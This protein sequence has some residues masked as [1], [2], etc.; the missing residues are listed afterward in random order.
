MGGKIIA[1]CYPSGEHDML[2]IVEVPDDTTA[3]G[4]ALVV[5]AGGAVR[6][7]SPPGCWP[8]GNGSSACERRSSLN[9]AQPAG[10]AI[11]VMR[12]QNL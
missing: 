6:C 10:H 12:G 9:T 1:G 2:V 4:S 11:C 7:A 3:A 8:G 5:I